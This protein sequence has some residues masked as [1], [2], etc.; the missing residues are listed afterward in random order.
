MDKRKGVVILRE[1]KVYIE[2]ALDK[3]TKE[4]ADAGFEN[5]LELRN[6]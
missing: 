3:A 5:V 2:A 4:L 6:K 1:L